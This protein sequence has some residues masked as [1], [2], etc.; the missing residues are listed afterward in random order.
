MLE[1]LISENSSKIARII[2]INKAG[3]IQ[4]LYMPVIVPKVFA[5]EVDTTAIIGNIFD[6]HSK[7]SFMFTDTS[8]IGLAFVIK[9]F[10]NV[11]NEI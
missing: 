3:G 7:P 11:P 6:I 2:E 8:D 1:K 4:S 5:D 9:A 10:A